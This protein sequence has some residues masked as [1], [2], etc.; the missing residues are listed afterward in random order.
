MSACFCGC[1]PAD[2]PHG[3]ALRL[4]LSRNST[5]TRTHN[6]VAPDLQAASQLDRFLPLCPITSRYNVIPAGY[7]K[8]L[9]ADSSHEILV[10]Q[11][12]ARMRSQLIS[13]GLRKQKS[14]DQSPR[15]SLG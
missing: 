2:G 15:K 12:S 8:R 13:R 4:P 3:T 5:C 10:G 6:L 7:E 1:I 11:A 14:F 9:Q